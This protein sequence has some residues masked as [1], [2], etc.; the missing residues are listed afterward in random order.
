MSRILSEQRETLTAGKLGGRADPALYVTPLLWGLRG[1]VV[2]LLCFKVFLIYRININWDEFVYLAK[3]IE[4]QNGKSLPLI[5]T[6]YVHPFAWL[7]QVQGFEIEKMQAA[8]LAVAVLGIASSG[9][10]Y[11]IARR[12]VSELAALCAI[13]LYLADP[14]LLKHAYSFR[15]DPLCAFL[16]LAAVYGFL[17]SAERRLPAI[18]GGVSLALAFMISIK[19]VFYALP[20]GCLF[21]GLL[22]IEGR[23]AWG[24][25]LAFSL[26]FLLAVAVL[27][28]LHSLVMNSPA[29]QVS[30]PEIA[31]VETETEGIGERL[32]GI[33]QKV[34]LETSFFPRWRRFLVLFGGNPMLWL[35]I[36]GGIALAARSV[37]RDGL[38]ERELVVLAAGSLLL[39]LL[40]YRNAYP[41]FYVFFLPLLF[42]GIGYLLDAL[43]A[44]LR[45]KPLKGVLAAVFLVTLIG[46]AS[47]SFAKAAYEQSADNQVAQREIIE[48][49]HELF[50]E[51]VPYIDRNS[52]IAS[53][54]KVGFFMSTWGMEDYRARGNPIMREILLRE[55][56]QF[57][58]ANV[59]VLRIDDPDWFGE[60][61]SY[62]RLLDEDYLV[63]QDNFIPYWGALY[64]LGKRF[65]NLGTDPVE[66]EL[67]VPGDYQVVSEGSVVI[68]GKSIDAGRTIGLAAGEHQVSVNEE[69]ASVMLRLAGLPEPWKRAPMDFPIYSGL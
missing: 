39:P 9:L 63:L 60:E 61:E 31:A 24:R 69:G 41:Y 1:L 34:L 52:M 43:C 19:S 65:E 8:R 29:P 28:S 3:I 64:V 62:Y 37:L 12:Y 5:Q 46:H 47:W 58:V 57:L 44:S 7:G 2:L 35:A 20:L 32:Q 26:A 45:G 68:D 6:F 54:P 49:V 17:V 38:R 40:V 22:K 18:A 14:N 36:F 30:S 27:W 51:P 33:A 15:A 66:F 48:L 25:I 11:A 67:L 55:Q 56:P 42:V 23:A 59:D 13:V 53:F 50:P 21:L 16:F 4:F 10:L